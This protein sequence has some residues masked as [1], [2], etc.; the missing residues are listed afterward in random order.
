MD[1]S[2]YAVESQV[3]E[4][5]WWFVGRRTL[6]RKTLQGLKLP[7]AAA[8]LDV[9]TSTGANLRLLQDMGFANVCGLD[10]SDEAIRYCRERQLAPVRQ[11]DVCAMPFLDAQFDLVLATDIIE[12]VDDD[13]QALREIRRVL[14]PSGWALLTVPA[15]ASLWGLQDDVAHHKRR[16]RH[17]ELLQKLQTAGLRKHES[18]YFNF[19]L[20]SPIWAARQ[21][22]PLLPVELKSE[23]QINSSLINRLLK[24][25][26]LADVISARTLHVPF[27]VSLLALVARDAT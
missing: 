7:R 27:G 20:F 5:H 14:K 4:T 25:V 2:V 1:R 11:G 18:F 26:F 24:V 13:A 6:F 8:I 19:F 9:G 3:Q 16:Y 21:V 22:L 17:R 12:H 15:F 23:N 10:P